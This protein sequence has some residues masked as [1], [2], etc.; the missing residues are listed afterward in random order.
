MQQTPVNEQLGPEKNTI[1]ALEQ[2]GS[3]D[4]AGQLTSYD[5]EIF[6]AMH[7]VTG[8][9]QHKNFRIKQTLVSLDNL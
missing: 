4:I 2:M 6:S 9:P 1:D 5:W 3:K 7:E 8:I